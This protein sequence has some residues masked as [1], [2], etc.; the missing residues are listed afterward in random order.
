MNNLKENKKPTLNMYDNDFMKW[1]ND[2]KRYCLHVQRDE[3]PESP[4]DW[5]NVSIMACFH[6][7][8]NLGDAVPEK[9]AEEFWRR[10]VRENVFESEIIAA[11]KE[12]KLTGIR[13]AKCKDS[14][15]NGLV[16]I[17][18]TSQWRSPAG[19]S[20]PEE[21]LEYEAVAENTVA[22]Y[23]MDDLS[24]SHCMTLMEPYAEWM[25]LW[26]YDHSG[27]TMSCGARTGQ[28]ADRWDS[29]CVGWIIALKAAVMN[30][31]L[32]Y[33]LDENGEKIKEVHQHENAPS[34]WSYKTQRLTEETWRNRAIEA[35]KVDVEIYDQFLT[36]EVYGFTLYEA[37][38]VE[39]DAEPEWIEVDSCWGFFGSDILENGICEQVSCGL[40]EA[41]LSGN[42]ETGEAE[43]H[44][45]TY[46]TF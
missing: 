30:E 19:N 1:E 41:I 5:D 15:K 10:L 2:G 35:M 21:F 26:L 8:Y 37:E 42:Y 17:Y 18:E 29:R 32:D 27:I 28:Y 36:G 9:D 22:G 38:P 14:E 45:N 31:L 20:E 33:V 13:I 3:F 6:P 25:P 16:D 24:I 11:A 23:L 4:R 34:T 43:V 7:R 40:E 46:Y 39:D 44:V 12:G